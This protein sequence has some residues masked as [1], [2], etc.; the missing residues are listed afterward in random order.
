M[1][2]VSPIP[3]SLL[4][5]SSSSPS[6]SVSSPRVELK[7]RKTACPP[8]IY[9]IPPIISAAAAAPAKA[10]WLGGIMFGLMF[11]AGPANPIPDPMDIPLAPKDPIPAPPWPL[12]SLEGV[13]RPTF[14]RR[15]MTSMPLK[16]FRAAEAMRSFWNSTNLN[17]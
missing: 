7:V 17:K 16:M 1:N 5:H 15:P 4:T 12:S 11:I 8:S 6:K 9:L 14:R 2:Y 13:G 10:C 3:P